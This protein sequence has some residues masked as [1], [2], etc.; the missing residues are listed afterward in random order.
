MAVWT[1]A[2]L[3]YG[4]EIPA[5]DTSD[6]ENALRPLTSD[7]KYLTAGPYDRDRLYLA[8]ASHA[9]DLGTPIT[10][11]L[12][13]SPAQ[14]AQWQAELDEALRALGLPPGPMP[15]WHLIANQD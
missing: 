1:T 15:E 5:R 4:F 6:V 12:N 13:A 14:Y 2:Y 11:D 3:I 9:A 7:V 8:T 10:C